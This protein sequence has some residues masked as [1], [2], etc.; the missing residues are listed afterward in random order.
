MR[1]RVVIVGPGRVGLALGQA[2]AEAGEL[3]DLVYCGRRPDPPTHP[4]F[5]QGF[6]RYVYGLEPPRQGTTAVFLTVTDDAIPGMAEFLSLQGPAPEGCPVFHC[7]GALS[8]DALEPLHV[9]GYQ[10]GSFHPLLSIARPLE[11][12]AHFSGAAVAISGEPEALVVGRRLANALGA[13]TILIPTNR[14]VLYHA[15]GVFA[16]NYLLVLLEAARR[17]LVQ[18]GAGD[19]DAV[20]ALIPLVR[21]TL[22]NLEAFGTAGALTGPVS[23][24]DAETVD[25][26]LRV[27]EPRDQDIYRTLGREALELARE[28]IPDEVAERLAHLLAHRG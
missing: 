25:L 13:R 14:R 2:L 22:D 8:T 24:G 28:G 11:G 26:H 20:A 4:L 19:E 18:A 12:A 5:T 9:R 10:V 6:A 7:S 3:D 16:S 15:A 21:S 1:E 17:L 27:L 23:R